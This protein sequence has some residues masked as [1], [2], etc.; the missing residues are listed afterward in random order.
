[1]FV[2]E[3]TRLLLERGEQGGVQAIPPTLR[4]SLAA[5]LDRLGSAREIA[6][7]GAVLGR[8]FSYDLLRE[9]ASRTAPDLSETGHSGLDEASLRSALDRLL[10]ADLLFVEGVSPEATYRFKHAL[11]QDAAYDSLLKSR[12][13]GL[14]R[15]AA[16]ALIRARGEAEA[17]AH[18]FAEAG[19]DGLAIE[20]WGNAGDEAL[21]RAAFKEAIAHL[22]KAIAM[23]DKAGMETSRQGTGD[24]A[25]SNRV[26]KLHTDYGHAVMWSKGFAADDTSAA[27]ARVSELASQTGDSLERN[28]VNQ[29]R[30]IASFIRG[31]L[32]VARDQVELFLR[33]AEAS[34]RIMDIGAA[35]RSVGL[36][37]LFQG[38]F[39]LAKFHLQR[40]LADHVAERDIDARRL[41]GTDTGVTTKAFMSPLAWIMGKP[42]YARKLI[43]E[44][45][46][47][48]NEAEH[49]ATIATNHLFLTRLEIN[50]DDPAAAQPA[51]QALLTFSKAHDMAL[52]AIYGEIFSS[53]ANGRLTDPEA[54]ARRLIPGTSTALRSFCRTRRCIQSRNGAGSVLVW[55]LLPSSASPTSITRCG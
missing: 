17:I 53:W 8:G 51:A 21:R 7:I 10:S 52:Y 55:M 29:A 48:G 5:R 50:R 19:L 32:N 2:E 6:Q 4:Q 23:A 27:Y 33:E 16:E 42:D 3:V 9:V 38:D 1:L 22:G 28:V 41:F 36:T 31:D 43:D 20:W 25:I 13:Q 26:L 46:R 35:H 44:A 40:A 24:A 39:K 12:Q 34:R 47:E 15:L 37:C 11:I 45:I 14:H 30:W 54:G 18:H 49:V